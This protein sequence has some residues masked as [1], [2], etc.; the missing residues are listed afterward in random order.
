MTTIKRFLDAVKAK[1]LE[2]ASVL[3]HAL[4]ENTKPLA[5]S[6][7]AKARGE[8]E[9]VSRFKRG[10]NGQNYASTGGTGRGHGQSRI[11]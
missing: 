10:I 9:R 5:R 7:M 6:V 2:A 8:E 11:G 4:P 1:D 3:F